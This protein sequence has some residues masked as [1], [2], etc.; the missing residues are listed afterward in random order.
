MRSGHARG[1]RRDDRGGWGKERRGSPPEVLDDLYWFVGD[2]GT[3]RDRDEKP[4]ELEVGGGR[5]E[6]KGAG[7]DEQISL[8][9]PR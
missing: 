8:L 2:V 3:G 4:R 7:K 5:R 6:E 9:Q 1:A